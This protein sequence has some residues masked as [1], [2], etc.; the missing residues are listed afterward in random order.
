[1]HRQA[2]P[3]PH[4][5][6]YYGWDQGNMAVVQNMSGIIASEVGKGLGVAMQNV[7]KAG[8]S[9]LAGN[10]A[11]DDAKPYTQD[12]IATLLGFHG[13][14]NVAYLTKI[15]RLFKSSKLPNYDYLRRTIK[16]EMIRWADGQRCWIE[17]GVYFDNKTLDE[18]IALRFNPGDSTALYSSADK[19]IS[20]L[21]CGAPTS[22]HLEDLRRQEEVHARRFTNRDHHGAMYRPLYDELRSRL[23]RGGGGGGGP[24]E[25]EEVGVVASGGRHND[26]D[27]GR[28]ARFDDF[29]PAFFHAL[30]HYFPSEAAADHHV[31]AGA[32]GGDD[33]DRVLGEENR[34]DGDDDRRPPPSSSSS[35]SSL[36]LLLPRP[37]SATLVLRTFGTDLPRVARCVSEFAR[38][39]HPSFP[40]Y[41][42]RNLIFEEGDLMR[43]RW[44]TTTT[45]TTRRRR[46]EKER[47]GDD[48]GG[49]ADGE[50]GLVYELHHQCDRHHRCYSG[51]D[52]IL[53]HLQSRTVVGIRDDYEFW[54]DNDQKPWSGKPVW[55]RRRKDDSGGGR[56]VDDIGGGSCEGDE[57]RRRRRSRRRRRRLPMRH[58]HHHILLDDNIHNDPNDGI[59]AIRVPMP[60]RETY[61]FDDDDC[62]ED[63]VQTMTTTTTTT[64]RTA[65]SYVSLRGNDL[66]EMHG[67]HLIRVPTLRPLLEDDWFV[68]RI[69]DA[70]W[71]IFLDDE[72]EEGEEDEEVGDSQE[73]IIDRKEHLLDSRTSTSNCL[74]LSNRNLSEDDFNLGTIS[75]LLLPSLKGIDVSRNSLKR[76]PDQIFSFSV[77]LTHLDVSR[78]SLRGLPVEIGSL[79]NLIRLVA[80]SNNLRMTQLPLDALASLQ[81][82]ELLDLRY[83]RKMKRAAF[84]MLQGALLPNNSKLEIRCTALDPSSFS[85]SVHH[86]QEEAVTQGKEKTKLSACDRDATLIRSQLEP[87][88]T[89]Q[90]RKRLEHS[91]GV[92]LSGE[93]AEGERT[94]D[95]EFVMKTLLDCYEKHGPR[96]IWKERGIPASPER[97]TSLLAELRAISWPRL[98][99]RPKI[100]AEHYMILQKPGSGKPESARTRNETAKLTRYRKLFDMAVEALAEIDP[101]FAERF[102]ALAITKNFV[103]S[104]HIDTLNVGPFYGL[105][106][107]SLQVPSS[108]KQLL[109]SH[110]LQSNHLNLEENM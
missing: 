109:F 58:D 26:E 64:T 68:R 47:S 82:L 42:N 79:T 6:K 66:L 77:M 85:S 35:S 89:P 56:V 101:T 18:W 30:A 72:E 29:V 50:E 100:R 83:N 71:R 36:P 84:E 13:A 32:D 97:L 60:V 28:R 24:E 88:S 87:L 48:G 44:T 93:G 31:V 75:S 62:D 23:L 61:E 37:S 12:Q 9:Q 57:C 94:Y 15:W 65:T 103:G 20:I 105:S 102:T 74:I 95:R 107:T 27:G 17:E 90:L 104:P 4:E 45:T 7:A 55:A 99:E 22:A 3:R 25:E 54:R 33:D 106:L 19:G 40:N 108:H 16:G 51:D 70:R 78:N 34:P 92:S 52:E 73:K 10:G 69:E 67:K 5:H 91:F 98:R 8:P 43:G 2:S 59:G 110:H 80:L 53:G 14:M 39:G 38:G 21:K 1:M 46:A 41:H 86:D 49:G 63:I 81:Q 96:R 76:I 11:S